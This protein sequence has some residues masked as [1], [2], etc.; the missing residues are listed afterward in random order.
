MIDSFRCKETKKVW[1]RKFSK[2]FPPEIQGRARR[3]LIAI[4]ISESI[5]DLRVPP[6]NFLEVLKDDRKGQYS[7]RINDQWRI[8]FEWKDGNA[9]NVEIVDYH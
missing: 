3:K 9:C 8:C 6:S 4:S 1:Y 2:K 7:I 5:N